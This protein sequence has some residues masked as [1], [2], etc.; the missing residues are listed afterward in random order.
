MDSDSD[1]SFDI[2]DVSSDAFDT[3]D[4][5]DLDIAEEPAAM[6]ELVSQATESVETEPVPEMTVPEMD[7]APDL[8]AE[9]DERLDPLATESPNLEMEGNSDLPEAPISATEP[10]LNQEMSQSDLE[11]QSSIA[12]DIDL[13]HMQED[14]H[15]Q[16]NGLPLESDAPFSP[17]FASAARDA[18]WEFDEQERADM[19]RINDAIDEVYGPNEATGTD[20]INEVPTTTSVE[21]LPDSGGDN[22]N[23]GDL[24]ASEPTEDVEVS[25]GQMLEIPTDSNLDTTDSSQSS[26][27]PEEPS[28]DSPVDIGATSSATDAQ[29]GGIAGSEQLSPDQD[30]VDVREV[31]ETQPFQEA[32]IESDSPIYSDGGLEY[33]TIPMPDIE[34]EPNV[35]SEGFRSEISGGFGKG[36]ID[37]SDIPEVAPASSQ[38]DLSAEEVSFNQSTLDSAT[39]VAENLS[40]IQELQ[41]QVWES[42][43]IDER[44]TALQQAEN[45]LANLQG[46][47]ALQVESQE[48]APNEYGFF[49][50]ERLVVNTNHIAVDMPVDEN[51]DTVIHEGRHAYQQ[52]AVENPGTVPEAVRVAWEQNM[53]NYKPQSVYG[54]EIY[55]SQ[56]IENDAFNFAGTIRNG[57]YGK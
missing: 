47:P 41:P 35:E 5:P 31:G 11:L 10:A 19:E 38:L 49:D 8:N 13:N 23:T 29:M 53:E 52:F 3:S 57:V 20:S 45:T 51:L 55:Q 17:E 22:S 30:W 33:E 32:E 14:L 6:E 39:E 50:G 36:T 16:V 1:A 48:M 56:P 15:R 26:E 24:P 2:G 54:M 42:L 18:A 21:T 7:T 46:R 12:Q 25:P 27:I 44:F 34:R 28:V 9:V 43:G 4:M 40:Q 37:D